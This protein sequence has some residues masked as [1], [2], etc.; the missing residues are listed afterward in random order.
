MR[1][2]Q[3]L[4]RRARTERQLDSELRSH[5][6]QQIADYVATGMTQQEARRRARLEFGGLEQ[7]KEECRDVG[8]ARFIENLIQDVRYGL[9]QLR[10]NPGFTAV[11]VITLA[12]GIGATAAIFSVAN[13]VLF[14]SLPFNHPGRLVVIKMKQMRSGTVYDDLSFP[15]FE[16]W[17]T[18]NRVFAGMAV[19][20]DADGTLVANRAAIHVE[21]ET[22]SANLFSLLG[23]RPLLGR[24]FL[25]SEDKP[26]GGG[27]PIILSYR[28]WQQYFS[29]SD[30][31]LGQTVNLDGHPY[32]IVGVMRPNFQFPIQAEPI[33]FWRTIARD[34]PSM[35][36]D[37]GDHYTEA[38]AR[39]K[40]G[41]A[42]SKAQSDMS[43]IEHWLGKQYPKTDSDE[44]AQLVSEMNELVGNIRPVLW[45]LLGAVGFLLLI[46]SVN[47]AT[48][49]LA[50]ADARQK[51]IGIR[52]ALGAGQLRIARQM[53]T[54]SALLVAVGAG[55]GL[56]V[57]W[58][59]VGIWVRLGP[60]DIP[61]LTEA[62]IDGRVLLFTV[63]VSAAV[64]MMF[65]VVP[66]LSTS[67]VSLNTS[68]RE[69]ATTLTEST[70]RRRR[71]NVLAVAQVALALVLLVGAGLAMNSFIRM[72]HVKPGFDPDHVITMTIDGP[73]GLRHSQRAPFF[74]GLLARIRVLP[75]V[76]SA[77]AAFNLPLGG[78]DIEAGFTI[79]GRPGS[80][81]N[82]QVASIGVVAPGYFKTM[83]IRVLKGRGFSEHDLMDTTPVII[84]NETLARH[85]F[86][87]QDPLGQ[88]IEPGLAVGSSKPPMRK[89]V[90]VVADVK[91]KNLRAAAGLQTYTP[92]AQLPFSTS[93]TV[94][95][96][97]A[98]APE[99]IAGA[100]R[101]V[102][103]R[104]DKGLPVYDVRT[105]NQYVSD[106]VATPRFDALLLG[107]FAG[108]SLII[109]TVGIYGVIAYSVTH[110]THEIGIRIALGAKGGDVLRLVMGQGMNL[111]LT[112]VAIG[113]L[114]AWALTRFLSSLLYDVG[115]MD[116]PTLVAMSF[117]L[118][119][120]A[121][122][123]CYFPA[124]R[125][126]KVDPMVAL[127]HE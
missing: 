64:A 57:A 51:E 6:E 60:K 125:A 66:G 23:V 107:I 61:R 36:A 98:V 76:V 34:S 41:V 110:R 97:T 72:S 81:G 115:S 109:T 46:A 20:R 119:G 91:S 112:G 13:A 90:G 92:Q 50:R 69:G 84:V 100:V 35:M 127:R 108:L 31:I 113:L 96:R 29:G 117:I 24:A 93:M 78:N 120:A 102:V 116:P 101:R 67:R 56:L 37:R 47:L 88:R 38:I 42:L 105:M 21:G 19:Y 27:L 71:R 30:N 62:A 17:R 114:G 3:R 22:V 124:R 65:G 2:Y 82:L 79:Q 77:S 54:E 58:T 4:F 118:I 95:I 15:D 63:A 122:L 94:V 49:L 85:F 68:L 103:Q 18:G 89:I 52:L 11:A 28:L 70:G 80:P 44:D 87:N 40:P 86:G 59:A 45:V 73:S 104:I 7:M 126:A 5:L 39:L 33:D 83:G 74:S 9:R 12:L 53:L 123:A 16:D 75:G 1:W 43:V 106:T 25:P 55:C 14:R 99:S 32:V 111:A 26:G 8:A 48:L 10:R 121:L